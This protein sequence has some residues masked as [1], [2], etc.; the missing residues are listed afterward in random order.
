MVLLIARYAAKNHKETNRL[1]LL[2]DSLTDVEAHAAIRFC[3]TVDPSA[4]DI[5]HH[6]VSDQPPQ[7]IDDSA[8]TKFR[9]YQDNALKLERNAKQLQERTNK[10]EAAGSQHKSFR[11]RTQ[12][13]V[14][15][16]SR[17]R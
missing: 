9:L 12:T 13:N 6:H 11:T 2:L 10:L 5:P 16:V 17:S 15:L 1:Q 4:L 3:K 7:D 8:L 14:K